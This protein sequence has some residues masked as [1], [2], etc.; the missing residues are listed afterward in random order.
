MAVRRSDLVNK[1]LKSSSQASFKVSSS[2]YLYLYLRLTPRQ[3]LSCLPRNGPSDSRN[4][5]YNLQGRPLQRTEQSEEN[6]SAF[7]NSGI[8]RRPTAGLLARCS[9]A[10]A[11]P[12]KIYE[13]KT[14]LQPRVFPKEIAYHYQSSYTSRDQSRYR[15]L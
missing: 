1:Y 15:F 3:M 9:E 8:K 4:S 10:E 2:L 11:N 5:P 12:F 14:V 6:E 13:S 7:L